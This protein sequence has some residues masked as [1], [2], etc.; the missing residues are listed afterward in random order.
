MKT[1]MS[2]PPCQAGTSFQLKKEGPDGIMCDMYG[3]KATAVALRQAYGTVAHPTA[4]KTYIKFS[5]R[6]L[7]LRAF[8]LSDI[9]LFMHVCDNQPS[10]CF[11]ES[12]CERPFSCV[13]FSF[14][15]LLPPIH[16]RSSAGSSSRKRLGSHNMRSP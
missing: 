13:D 16:S 10:I 6:P 14:D 9:Y 15:P 3:H 11:N 12:R 2:N 7:R 5:L 1:L 8:A 4:I